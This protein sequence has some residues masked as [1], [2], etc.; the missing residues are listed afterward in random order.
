MTYVYV[1]VSRVRRKAL[2]GMGVSS[3]S[4]LEAYVLRTPSALA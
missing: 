2:T 3:L 1:S 4:L